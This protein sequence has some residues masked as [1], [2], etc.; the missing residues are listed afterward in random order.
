M[1]GETM[2][3]TSQDRQRSIQISTHDRNIL[4][5]LAG[6]VAE[7]ST[8]P[9]DEEKKHCGSSSNALEA[10][11]SLIFCDP[12][13][14]WNEIITADQLQCHGDLAPR[15]GDEIEEGNLLG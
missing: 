15:M 10:T 9:I 4:R 7:L 12:E 2:S 6:R 5:L 8:R 11:S 13:N 1:L 3:E 14:G